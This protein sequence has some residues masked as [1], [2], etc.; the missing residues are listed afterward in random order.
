MFL[1][2]AV[3]S[4]FLPSADLRFA[5]KLDSHVNSFCLLP[6]SLVHISIIH[7]GCP[8][9]RTIGIVSISRPTIAA[10]WQAREIKIST[11]CMLRSATQCDCWQ[12]RD[13]TTA[14]SIGAATQL[15]SG[16]DLQLSSPDAKTLLLLLVVMTTK[17]TLSLL[18]LL[19]VGVG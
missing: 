1:C 5:R 16:S 4:R 17:K 3:I 11:C 12:G 10:A 18:L 19:S 2:V 15:E 6:P 13:N 14:S 9:T 8:P 7:C